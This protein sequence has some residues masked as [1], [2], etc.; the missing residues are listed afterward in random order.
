VIRPDDIFEWYDGPIIAAVRCPKCDSCAILELV[1][2][3]PRH[4]IRIFAM[5]PVSR[6]AVDLYLRNK[7][8]GSCDPSRYESELHALL[9]AAG[10]PA[11][12]VAYDVDA[13]APVASRPFPAGE[14]LSSAPWQTRIPAPDDLRWFTLVGVPKRS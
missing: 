11:H 3:E 1:D 2:R 6:D 8:R 10:A 14:A 4:P 5:R 7:E 12:L 13:G 9:C